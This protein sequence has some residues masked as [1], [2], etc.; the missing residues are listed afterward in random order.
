VRIGRRPSASSGRPE[1]ARGRLFLTAA[2]TVAGLALF[3]YVVRRAG[4]AEILDGIQRVG[5]GLAVLLLLAGFRF[6]LRSQ[7]WRLCMPDAARLPLGRAFRAFLAGDAVGNITPLGLVASEPTKVFLSRHHLATRDA[8]ASLAAE[9]VIYA[10]S[11]ATMVS[12]GLLVV[13]LTVPLPASWRWTLGA[14]LVGIAAAVI[15]GRRLLRGTW[16]ESRGS[17]PKWREQV[18]SVRQAVA[19]FSAGQTGRFQRAY[20]LDLLYHAAAVLEVFLTLRW[21]LGDRSPSLTQAIAFEALNR[22]VVVA[23]KFVPF[24]VGV[25]EALTGAA[26]PLLSLDPAAGITLAVVRK[27]RNLF[28]TGVGL[29]IIAAHPAQSAPP[30]SSSGSASAHQS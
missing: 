10:T 30:A 11:V 12:F 7:C 26:A 5:W 15:A 29:A 24:R 14:A 27:V 4:A 17:R 19:A 25:D 28:W 13:L 22:A 16:D 23:F 9:N 21:V 8:V 6:V 18:A 1:S 2:S 3:A 20:A